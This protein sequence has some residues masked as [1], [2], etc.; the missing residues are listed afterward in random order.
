MDPAAA[1]P[2]ARIILQRRRPPLALALFPLVA[3]PATRGSRAALPLVASPAGGWTPSRLRLPADGAPTKSAPTWAS[4][5]RRGAARDDV[6]GAVRERRGS[7]VI[8]AFFFG[9]NALG[10]LGFEIY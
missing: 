3:V 6:A 4:W 8:V 10:K 2:I 5:G 9:I 7:C 1:F